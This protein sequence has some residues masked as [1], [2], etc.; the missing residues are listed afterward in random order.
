MDNI[1]KIG[2]KGQFEDGEA[3]I[4]GKM[5]L[6]DEDG[7]KWNH[8]QLR[9]NDEVFWIREYEDEGKSC[10]ELLSEIETEDTESEIDLADEIFADW[11]NLRHLIMRSNVKIDSIEGEIVESPE[12]D[13]ILKIADVSFGDE[14]EEIELEDDEVLVDTCIMWSEVETWVYGIEY[15]EAEDIKKMFNK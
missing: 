1:L 10:Y 15:F 7:S 13:E 8:W 3:T 14:D 9:S 6:V 2:L 5:T 4:I 11:R 12:K